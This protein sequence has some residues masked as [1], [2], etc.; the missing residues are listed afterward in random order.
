MME[1]NGIYQ[2]KE[3]DN[4]DYINFLKQ[5]HKVIDLSKVDKEKEKS[6]IFKAN[7]EFY[8]FH[9]LNDIPFDDA[10]NL[11]ATEEVRK[12]E[13]INQEQEIKRIS[14][15]IDDYRSSETLKSAKLLTKKLQ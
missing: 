2:R 5:M 4:F 6:N 3:L 14:K 9:H 7:E 15:I 13:R 12:L 1:E 10:G 11:L 8:Q